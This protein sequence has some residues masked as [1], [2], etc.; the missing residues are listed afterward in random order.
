MLFGV[1][2]FRLFLHREPT[3]M[4]K[5]FDG[6]SGLVKTAMQ[7]NPLSG[8]CYIFINRRRDRMKML[9]WESTGFMLYYKLLEKGTFELP[10]IVQDATSTEL[11][12]DELVMLLEGIELQSIKRRPRFRRSPT[13]AKAA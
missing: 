12:W 5:G 1:A 8:D 2:N 9:V 4:R 10:P 13:S 3:D 11:A 7:Q 6:L